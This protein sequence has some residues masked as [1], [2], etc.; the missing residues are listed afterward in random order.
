MVLVKNYVEYVK[1]ME[2]DVLE[3]LIFFFKLLS[4]FIGLGDLIIFF[5]MSK[6]V[7][8][9]V[10]LVVIIGKC[11]KCVLVEKVIDYVMGYIIMFD[12]IVC[13]F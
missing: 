5:R 7:D 2:S 6:R 10:E 11:V 13:D 1:E 8:Y 4:V 12:I 3:K 9:E